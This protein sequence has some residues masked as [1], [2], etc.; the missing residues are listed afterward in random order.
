M[1]AEYPLLGIAVAA[2]LREPMTDRV[3]VVQEAAVYPA[4]TAGAH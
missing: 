3:V 4:G 2:E 1:R